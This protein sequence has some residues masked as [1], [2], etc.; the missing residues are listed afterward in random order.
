MFSLP[1]CTD[2]MMRE[3]QTGMMGEP[4]GANETILHRNGSV[5]TKER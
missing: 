3:P 2:G 4:V 5:W 1:P